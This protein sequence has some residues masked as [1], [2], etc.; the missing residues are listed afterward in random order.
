M[1]EAP[2]RTLGTI[3]LRIEL[4]RV[5]GWVA[6]ASIAILLVSYLRLF[7]VQTYGLD[8]PIGNFRYF[9]L[10]EE[11]TL[12]AWYSSIVILACG[13]LLLAISRLSKQS[14]SVDVLRWTILGL[15]F[16][17]MG[18]DEAVSIHERL[19][20]PIREGFDLGGV[21][22]FA[23]VA[24]ALFIVAA[25][26]LYMA[27]LLVRLPFRSAALFLLAG[28]LY[29]GGALG[30]EMVGGSV[31]SGPGTETLLYQLIVTV[32]ETLEIAGFTLF[33]VSLVDHIGRSWPLWSLSVRAG[34]EKDLRHPSPT[35]GHAVEA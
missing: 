33:F 24:P 7:F 9:D 8:T 19:I 12:P 26:G 11:L 28:G 4:H 10:D 23:W 18:I 14:G 20:D 31:A 21:F 15:V 17:L 30:M 34:T 32:E 6:I 27:P 3:S 35:D 5:A 22:Y 1:R 29:V 25:L 13:I 2:Q 16:V